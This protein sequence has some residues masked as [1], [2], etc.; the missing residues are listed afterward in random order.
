[1]FKTEP[2]TC[3]IKPFYDVITLT[4]DIA[5]QERRIGKEPWFFQAT[6]C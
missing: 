1:M 3:L 6:M 2:L 5:T 4:K